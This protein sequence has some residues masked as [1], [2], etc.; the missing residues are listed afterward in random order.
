MKKRF[1][2]FIGLIFLFLQ[3]ISNADTIKIVTENSPLQAGTKNPQVLAIIPSG[4]MVERYSV[5][6]GFC[7]VSY[8]DQRGYVYCGYVNDNLSYDVI[9]NDGSSNYQNNASGGIM[10]QNTFDSNKD[11]KIELPY[12]LYTPSNT[13][14]KLPV[15]IFLHGSDEMG[16]NLDKLISPKNLPKYLK[17]Q[18]IALNAIVVMPQYK[19]NTDLPSL[20]PMLVNDLS[21]KYSIDMNRISV[22]GFS[23]GSAKAERVVGAKPD[24]YSA[25]VMV[26]GLADVSA[27]KLSKLPVRI[28]VGSLETN[29]LLNNS[30]A[31][32]K[33][34]NRN[35]GNA[36]FEVLQDNTHGKIP[37]T[38][39]LKTDTL[40]WMLSQSK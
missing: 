5:V 30:S 14:Q 29:S 40:K 18:T 1:L 2:I 34:I 7:E 6:D 24:M 36:T 12:W 19:D 32:A 16:T 4:T 38:V 8:N 20:I 39:L 9:I 37:G 31:F 27:E 25:L 10:T 26:S 15:V 13:N 28:Y 17:D 21:S 33:R 35:G 11:G 23:L 3:N 22:I